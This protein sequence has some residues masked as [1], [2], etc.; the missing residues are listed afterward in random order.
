MNI[1]KK[2]KKLLNLK[3]CGMREAKNIEDLQMVNPDFIGFIF[4]PFSPRYVKKNE[5]LERIQSYLSQIKKVGVFVD[6]SVTEIKKKSSRISFGLC[7]NIYKR[8]FVL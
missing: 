7:A 1:F 6:T 5:E 3:V 2:K 4:Y 8:R